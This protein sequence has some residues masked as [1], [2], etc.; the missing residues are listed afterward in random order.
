MEERTSPG[1]VVVTGASM[2]IGRAIATTLAAAS[3]IV[4]GIALE[5]ALLEEA[6]AEIGGTA[7]RGD[8]RDLDVLN[9]ARRS[10][11]KRGELRGW[12]NNAAIV[13]LAPLHLMEPDAIADLLDINLRAVVLGAREALRS[14]LANDTAGSIINIS[15]IHGQRGF[16]GYG[17]YDTAK[18]G[19][20]ALTRYVC[21]EYGH[22]GIRCN[23]VAPGAVRTAIVPPAAADEHPPSFTVKARDLAPMRRVSEPTEIA[24]AVAFLLDDRS[25]SIN[26]HVLAI[27]N[28]MSARAFGFPPDDSVK[29]GAE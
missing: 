10:A 13:Q 20:E 4:V 1:V 9:S 5:Q 15:S 11:E 24:E 23:A 12:V 6:M 29:F 28:G 16:P 8:V 22:L 26:G 7:I 27:D 3:W 21:T 14:F 18:G 25:F 19:V 2:G 17:A